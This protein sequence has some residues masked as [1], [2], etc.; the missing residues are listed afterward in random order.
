LLLGT[1]GFFFVVVVVT[2]CV[3]FFYLGSLGVILDLE[4]S[5]GYC[6]SM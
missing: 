1:L 5:E 2:Y 4:R 3:C 6:C